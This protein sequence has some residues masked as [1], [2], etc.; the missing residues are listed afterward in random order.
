MKSHNTSSLVSPTWPVPVRVSKSSIQGKGVFATTTI[1]ARQKI[2]EYEGEL[3]GLAE[4]R[5][6]AKHQPRIAIVEFEN[7]KAVDG[8]RGG[9]DFRY[10]N[11]S[12]S[13]NIYMRRFRN[14]VEFYALGAIKPGDELTCDYGESHHEGTR[15]CRC[16]SDRCRGYL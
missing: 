14:R 16:G 11:H 6:R 8:T 5:R 2:G 1:K 4:A 9:N 15:R 3:I 13:P 7:G 10:I 12:C